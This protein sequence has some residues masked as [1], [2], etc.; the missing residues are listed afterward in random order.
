MP[1]TCRFSASW[2]SASRIRMEAFVAASPEL[3]AARMIGVPRD[4]SIRSAMHECLRDGPG[5]GRRRF[6]LTGMPSTVWIPST[7]SRPASGNAG[8]TTSLL[9]PLARKAAAISARICPRRVE[10]DGFEQKAGIGEGRHGG[11]RSLCR[12]QRCRT[13]GCWCRSKRWPLLQ[14]G[15]FSRDQRRIA[16]REKGR[17]A[18]SGARQVIRDYSDEERWVLLHVG[19]NS[20]TVRAD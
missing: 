20:R 13:C 17:R 18:V 9:R 7:V 16:F 15:G 3:F 1:A 10:F 8:A 5:H 2:L 14:A 19:D 11:P 6:R 4:G 12:L